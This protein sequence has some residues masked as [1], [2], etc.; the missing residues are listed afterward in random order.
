MAKRNGPGRLIVTDRVKGKHHL[1]AVLRPMALLARIVLTDVEGGQNRAAVRSEIE[2]KNTPCRIG[3]WRVTLVYPWHL[4][5]R[6]EKRPAAGRNEAT[7]S[8]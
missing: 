3:R 1:A 6:G 8:Q 2:C 5:F 7:Q 4:T